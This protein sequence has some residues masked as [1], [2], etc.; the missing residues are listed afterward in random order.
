LPEALEHAEAAIQ[1]ATIYPDAH[2]TKTAALINL[3]RLV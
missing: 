3:L 2:Y 1:P